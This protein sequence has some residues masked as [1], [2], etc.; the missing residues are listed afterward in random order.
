MLF[1]S[2]YSLEF[3]F[4]ISDSYISKPYLLSLVS[5]PANPNQPEH[6]PQAFCFEFFQTI[7]TPAVCTELTTKGNRASSMPDQYSAECDRTSHRRSIA[8][9]WPTLGRSMLTIF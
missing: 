6:L 9:I 2:C 5:V 3:G 7:L 8:E 1:P 4:P